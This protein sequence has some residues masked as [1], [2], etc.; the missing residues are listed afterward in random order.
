MKVF[1]YIILKFSHFFGLFL[2]LGQAWSSCSW[3]LSVMVPSVSPLL[4]LKPNCSGGTFSPTTVLNIYYPLTLSVIVLSAESIALLSFTEPGFYRMWPLL[5]DKKP[6][7]RPESSSGTLW[8]RKHLSLAALDTVWE[9]VY[10]CN[11]EACRQKD[12]STSSTETCVLT[13]KSFNRKWEGVGQTLLGGQNGAVTS[14]A[15]FSQLHDATAGAPQ[16]HAVTSHIRMQTNALT[17][18]HT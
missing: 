5:D 14:A 18:S 10:T 3:L 12:A 7:F 4:H 8:L 2:V 6:A 16:G 11:S 15:L 1:H 9:C 13:R 17:T